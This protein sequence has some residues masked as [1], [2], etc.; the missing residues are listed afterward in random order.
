MFESHYVL[1]VPIISINFARK[2]RPKQKNTPFMKTS[3]LCFVFLFVLID[4]N[5]NNNNNLLRI[6]HIPQKKN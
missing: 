2:L 1:C 3:T 6:H 4:T 5:N